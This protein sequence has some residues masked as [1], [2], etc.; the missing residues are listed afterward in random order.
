MLT[1]ENLLIWIILYS[2]VAT[3]YEKRKTIS[4]NFSHWGPILTIRTG[5]GLKTIE[6]IA[7][8]YPK[9]WLIWGGIGSIIA[10]I[11][12]IIALLFISIS[13]FAMVLNPEQIAIDGPTD[14]VAIP[15][16]NRFLPI[17][18]APEILLGLL[19]GMVVHEM[20]HAILCRIGDME[21][22]STGVI[23]G[24]LI[25][26]GAFVEPEENSVEEA[27]SK[28]QINMFSAGIMNNFVVFVLTVVALY[29]IISLAIV[30]ATGVGLAHVNDN[31]PGELT[32]LETGDRIT[33][34]DNESVDTR[35]DLNFALNNNPSNLTVNE[36]SDYEI[37]DG[38]YVTQSP[39]L[40]SS[41]L[42]HGSTIKQVNG[43]NV[44]NE[45]QFSNI[46][47]NSS[48]Y[49]AEILLNEGNSTDIAVGA[50][51]T[52]I[53]THDF[54]SE[55]FYNE[56]NILILELDDE[57]VYNSDSIETFLNSTD[58]EM[59]NITYLNESGD[60]NTDKINSINDF[61]ESTII[62][63]DESGLGMS[64]LGVE[65][66]PSEMYYN[67][68]TPASSIGELLQNIY[69]LLILPLGSLIPGIEF[70]FPGFTPFI[71]NFFEVTVTDSV[72]ITSSIFFISGVLFWT[73]WINFNLA[74]FN[75]LPTFALDGGYIFHAMLDI[76]FGN[77]VSD[78][79]IWWIVFSVKIVVLALIMMLALAPV[80]LV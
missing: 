69:A 38:L 16:V 20:G 48:D 44:T 8:K 78:K 65:I 7:N 23:L 46:V 30:P 49:Y 33:A 52:F 74:L 14:I 31:S 43:E 42:T 57:R 22:K 56:D 60:L 1:W 53:E 80:I 54:E 13:V 15:G 59:H 75:C 72:V 77:Y 28:E 66:Y 79:I 47:Q 70:N 37:Y 41:D 32:G 21:V 39:V 19:I 55:T 27:N 4:T 50:Y 36:K 6:K 3:L 76:L 64:N 51:T 34:I 18:A 26:L 29:A 17:E 10:A 67:I 71:Q 73:A 58:S 35:D 12:S 40:M 2:V 11:T 62:S 5:K 24:A 68:L 9:G 25:P 61:E 45:M 63:E